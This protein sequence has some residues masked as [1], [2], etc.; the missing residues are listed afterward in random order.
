MDDVW[1][2]PYDSGNHQKYTPVYLTN[3][4]HSQGFPQ[5]V[6]YGLAVAP[7]VRIQGRIQGAKLRLKKIDRIGVV[8]YFTRVLVRP[9]G[10]RKYGWCPIAKLVYKSNFT[11]VFVGDISN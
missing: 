1:G 8:R 2:Y 6:S 5:Q 10:F 11:L 3:M 9:D 4:F 7:A